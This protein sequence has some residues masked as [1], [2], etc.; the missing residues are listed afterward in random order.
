MAQW[1][2]ALLLILPA[3]L[4]GWAAWRPGPIKIMLALLIVMALD[5]AT[6]GAFWLQPQ[7]RSRGDTIRLIAFVAVPAGLITLTALLA[8]TRGVA[9]LMTAKER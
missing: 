4:V 8:L 7:W 6:Y 3:A 9:G 1:S 5:L 2:P